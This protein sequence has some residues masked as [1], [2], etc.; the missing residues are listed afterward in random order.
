MRKN[1]NIS[2]Q[3]ILL[4]NL[5]FNDSSKKRLVKPNHLSINTSLPGDIFNKL[6]NYYLPYNKRL[7]LLLNIN[8]P[9]IKEL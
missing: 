8:I 1:I 7:K 9:W 5:D 3:S 6:S 2:H 4:S